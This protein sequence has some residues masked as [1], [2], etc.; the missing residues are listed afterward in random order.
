ME[1]YATRRRVAEYLNLI[2]RYAQNMFVISPRRKNIAFMMQYGLS[3]DD[4]KNIVLQ[5]GVQDYSRGP[6]SDD[7]AYLNRNDIWVFGK[8][9]LIEGQDIE[10]Y[11][12]TV[13]STHD[14]GLGCLCISFHESA[15]PIVYRYGGIE[16]EKIVL[17]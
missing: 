4:A 3:V 8:T 9:L 11:I 14:E 16:N 12:K 10:T 13:V 1:K 7:H 2:K 5:L 17:P 15:S 6:C